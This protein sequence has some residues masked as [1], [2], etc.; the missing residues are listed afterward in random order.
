MTPS[1]VPVV[2]TGE[3]LP[4]TVPISADERVKIELAGGYRVRVGG[5]VDTSILRRVLDVLERR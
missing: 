5:G 2:L 1:L 4:L 3:S